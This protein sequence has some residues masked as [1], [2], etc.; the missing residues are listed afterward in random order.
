MAVHGLIL[1]AVFPTGT[2]ITKLEQTHTSAEDGGE[3]V[4]TAEFFNG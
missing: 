4:I 1:P 3:N 2:V